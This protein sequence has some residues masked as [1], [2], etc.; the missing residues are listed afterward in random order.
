LAVGGKEG[1]E[2]TH[3]AHSGSTL[4]YNHQ[5]PSRTRGPVGCRPDGRAYEY[6]NNSTQQQLQQQSPSSTLSGQYKY[7]LTCLVSKYLYCCH[8]SLCRVSIAATSS[9][10]RVRNTLPLSLQLL[11]LP[12][13]FLI[14]TLF[15]RLSILKNYKIVGFPLRK[16]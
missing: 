3:V 5:H 8:R 10:T 4:L 7:W 11:I 2:I 14:V 9:Q 15:I 1:V 13:L 6:N 16:E 12:K